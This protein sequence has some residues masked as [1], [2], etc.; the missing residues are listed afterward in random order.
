MEYFFDNILKNGSIIASPSHEPDYNF[1]WIRDSAIVIKAIIELYCD[2]KSE[3]LKD[4]LKLIIYNYINIELEHIRYHPAEP[5]FCTNGYPFTGDWGRPQNDGPALRG[6]QC[7][8]LLKIFPERTMDLYAII[9]NDL[10]YT[11]SVIDDPCFDLWEEQNGFHLYTRLLQCK[12]LEMAKNIDYANFDIDNMLIRITELISH[13]FTNNIIYSSFGLKGDIIREYDSSVLLA[14]CHMDYKI[15]KTL[16]NKFNIKLLTFEKYAENMKNYFNNLYP[17]NNQLQIPFIGRYFDDSYFGGNP[18]IIST[19]AY[20]HF[21][22]HINNL[23]LIK[24]EYKRFMNLLINTKKMDLPEQIHK[25]T[26]Y[27][28]SVERLTWNYS[29]IILFF[30]DLKNNDIFTICNLL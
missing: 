12:F 7:I 1:H 24:E 14:L 30:K 3:D 18:W 8:R 11:I 26:G 15:P 9:Y 10:E 22:L 28:I 2:I 16:T 20:F 29:E 5:K 17:I 23:H 19:I 6:L 4:K 21:K 27:N 25:E 13:H